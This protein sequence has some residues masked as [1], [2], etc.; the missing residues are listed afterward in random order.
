MQ[1][2]FSVAQ[3][4][5]FLCGST[6]TE[7]QEWERAPYK[8]TLSFNQ[9]AHPFPLGA[10]LGIPHPQPAPVLCPFPWGVQLWGMWLHQ[11]FMEEGG[12]EGKQGKWYYSLEHEQVLTGIRAS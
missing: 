1:L 12:R 7:Q 4:V 8:E 2:T 10:S 3:P 11:G 6:G 5:S 9:K